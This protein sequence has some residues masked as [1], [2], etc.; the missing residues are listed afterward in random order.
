M[1]DDPEN[2]F[3]SAS[4]AGK[5]SEK[6][7][8][9][10]AP[11]VF[12]SAS[13][14]LSSTQEI[15]RSPSPELPPDESKYDDWF[16][17]VSPSIIIPAFTTPKIPMMGFSKASN[18]GI[19]MPSKEAFA[20]A[21][22]RMESWTKDYVEPDTAEQENTVNLIPP[23]LNTP[24]KPHPPLANRP[25]SPMTIVVPNA[26]EVPSTPS[27][28]AFSRPSLN[29][30]PGTPN[31]SHRPKPFKT[32]FLRQPH[33]TGNSAVGSPL[34][35]Q[36]PPFGFTTA[37]NHHPH[38]LAAPPILAPLSISSLPIF[39]TPLRKNNVTIVRTTPA[40]FKTPFKAG[41][42]APLASPVTYASP[43]VRKDGPS[44]KDNWAPRD[45]VAHISLSTRKQFFCLS[46]FRAFAPC[47][48]D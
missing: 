10:N 21:K 2:P 36:H 35:S 33:T 45:H 26:S 27:A 22:A 34:D 48:I 41:F 5:I 25:K 11:I 6:F 8:A 32:P 44:A 1:K 15:G 3:N 24:S 39:T 30:S 23:P 40:P 14:L 7:P 42:R 19:I 46:R 18:K 37:A 29:G 4:S 47:H 38:P 16:Q 20:K 31:T 28:P 12:A 43:R 13:S 9:V 17:P